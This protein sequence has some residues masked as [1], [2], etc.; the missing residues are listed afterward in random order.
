MREGGK[1]IYRGIYFAKYFS[2]GR[3]GVGGWLLWGKNEKGQGKKEAEKSGIL[4]QNG[5]LVFL[6]YNYIHLIYF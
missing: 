4:H 3:G 5:I 1:V 2:G 6:I